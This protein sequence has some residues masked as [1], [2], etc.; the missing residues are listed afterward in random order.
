MKNKK[1]I[2][3][4]VSIII[5]LAGIFFQQHQKAN[6]NKPAVSGAIID[7]SVKVEYGQPIKVARVIDG[8]T[9]EL[10]N[11]DRL[12]YV[13]VDT[14]EEFDSRKPVQCYAKEA[15]DKNREMVEGK[16]IKIYKDQTQFDKY[17]R[18]LGF[19]YLD[20]GTFV[21]LSLVQQGFAFSYPYSPDTSKSEQFNQAQASAKAANLGLWSTCTISSTS[22]G[23][24]QT[25]AVQ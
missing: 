20:D 23:R 11:G 9:I 19:V 14:P 15:A 16:E 3:L 10:I 22:S 6:Q 5:L 12:R 13:G 25:N 18:W 8:D 4:I 7:H 24:E 21:N 17:G 1:T 2:G